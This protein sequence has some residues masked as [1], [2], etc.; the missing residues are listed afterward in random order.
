MDPDEERQIENDIDLELQLPQESLISVMKLLLTRNF[1]DQR[2]IQIE[3]HTL[4]EQ[5]CKDRIEFMKS[6]HG[7]NKLKYLE[8]ETPDGI[9]KKI[10]RKFRLLYSDKIQDPN[11]L[12]RL[13]FP[14]P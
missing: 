3:L 1:S 12:Y 10:V 4:H 7:K 13:A 8:L 2:V 11:R 14:K 9:N 5:F 6:Q